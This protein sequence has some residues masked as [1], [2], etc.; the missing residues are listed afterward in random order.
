MG[1]D[2]G[3][4]SDTAEDVKQTTA[5]EA[6]PPFRDLY[7]NSDIVKALNEFGSSIVPLQ[8][9]GMMM[10]YAG[11]HMLHYISTVLKRKIFFPLHKAVSVQLLSNG[12]IL[13]TTKRTDCIIKRNG[14]HMRISEQEVT[15]T[16][17]SKAVVLSNGG[18]Q[19]IPDSQLKLFPQV[20]KDKYILADHL[21]RRDHF[22]SIMSRIKDQ[23]LKKIVIVGG[24]HSGFSCAWML[25]KGPATYNSN[26]VVKP[27]TNR[28]M[29]H[30]P[31]AQTK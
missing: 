2:E 20:P 29:E 17:R 10:N 4:D 14:S 11:N 9:I 6:I 28:F 3:S 5:Y 27:V 31:G 15:V 24:S 23:K 1:L 26:L 7:P 25:L 19:T 16:F 21:L 22:K 13:T 12:E 30:P 18:L 8:M